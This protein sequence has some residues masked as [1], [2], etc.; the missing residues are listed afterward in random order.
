MQIIIIIIQCFIVV[1]CFTSKVGTLRKPFEMKD[2]HPGENPQDSYN[3][4]GREVHLELHEGRTEDN[5]IAS[6][7]NK[8][9]SIARN[10]EPL[11]CV[12]LS[13]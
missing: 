8:Q 11:T 5:V 9:S 3:D 12:A 13:P 10:M 2:L 4:K 7:K 6:N 1:I